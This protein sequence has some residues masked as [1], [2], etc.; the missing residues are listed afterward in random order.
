M[1]EQLPFQFTKVQRNDLLQSWKREK[2]RSKATVLLDAL[3]PRIEIWHQMEPKDDRI[4][5]REIKSAAKKFLRHIEQL[6][7]FMDNNRLILSRVHDFK[8]DLHGGPKCFPRFWQDLQEIE[9]AT[10]KAVANIQL[11]TGPNNS[12]EAFLVG[13][14]AGL[15]VRVFDKN[16]SGSANSNFRQFLE[17]LSMVLDCN[18]G[19]GAVEDGLTGYRYVPSVNGFVSHDVKSIF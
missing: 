4:G 19:P 18:I 12:H 11:T 10:N 1:A 9:N 16:P 8:P 13:M 7:E 15:W 6:R 3:E 17:N 2:D 5:G 14:V